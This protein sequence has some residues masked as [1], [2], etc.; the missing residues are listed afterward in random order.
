MILFSFSILLNIFFL[1]TTA[2]SEDC[3][4][5]HNRYRSKHDAP[6]LRNEM[7]LIQ[8]AKARAADM[9]MTENFNHDNQ[10]LSQAGYGENLYMSWGSGQL[11][12][13]NCAN[14]VKAWYDERSMYK[15]YFSK[16]VGHYTQV[17]WKSTTSL[18]CATSGRSRSGNYYVV[19]NYHPPGNVIGQFDT[20]VIDD[21]FARSPTVAR[22]PYLS[23]SFTT[24]S[25]VIIITVIYNYLK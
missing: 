3:L 22:G 2:K 24:L 6:P 18:G 7:N 15:G 19:C 12:S 5:A 1:I 13:P 11:E 20:N 25:I 9:Q 16:G 10:K 17:V 14:V 4:E 8:F 21:G 23:A